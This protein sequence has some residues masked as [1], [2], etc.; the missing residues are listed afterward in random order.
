MRLNELQL[1]TEG[2][3]IV[4]CSRKWDHYGNSKNMLVVDKTTAFLISELTIQTDDEVADLEVI[5]PASR[6]QDMTVLWRI[7]QSKYSH[8]MTLNFSFTLRSFLS[9]AFVGAE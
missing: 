6:Y 3:Y 2:L 7:F 8:A 4:L 5:V 9:I 1:Y